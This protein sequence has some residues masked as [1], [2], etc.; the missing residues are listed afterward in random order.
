VEPPTSAGHNVTPAFFERLDLR[1]DLLRGFDAGEFFLAYQPIVSLIDGRIAGTEALLRW[2]H[3]RRGVLAPDSFITTAEDSGVI[4][5]IGGWA[6]DAALAQLVI[7]RSHGLTDEFFVSV[8]VSPRQLLVEDFAQ[9]VRSSMA[10]SSIEPEWVHLELTESS[11]IEGSTPSL[12]LLEATRALG[13]ELIV[14]DFGKGYSSLAYLSALPVSALK[15]DRS[16]IV[17]IEDEHD[18]LI[19]EAVISLARALRLDVIAEGIETLS[20]AKKLKQLGCEYAQGYIWCEPLAPAEFELWLNTYARAP[21][22][23]A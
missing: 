5:K 15:I 16:F 8:N 22:E 3:P 23:V 20:Q 18:A 21:I 10:A 1:S 17:G 11:L 13:V 19:V 4:V 6:L 12:Q 2:N 7:W 9:K 14:D